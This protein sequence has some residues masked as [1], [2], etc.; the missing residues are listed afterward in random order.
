MFPK[1]GYFTDYEEPNLYTQ[2]NSGLEEFK[3]ETN[4]LE[5]DEYQESELDVLGKG[6]EEEMYE[7]QNLL[8]ESSTVYTIY[9]Y[10]K[11]I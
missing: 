3:C 5:G 6:E 7:L 11:Y 10:I 8:L 1:E 9:I 4:P 2:D